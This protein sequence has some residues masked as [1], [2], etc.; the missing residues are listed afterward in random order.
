MRSRSLTPIALTLISFFF[1]AVMACVEII[2]QPPVIPADSD[3]IRFEG[4]IETYE[5]V[6]QTGSFDLHKDHA[7]KNDIDEKWKVKVLKSLEEEEYRIAHDS[8]SGK[9]TSSNS[10]N[11]MAFEYYPEGFIARP[12]SS[13]SGA[14]SNA[15][16]AVDGDE[17]VRSGEW[18]VR[19][20][21]KEVVRADHSVYLNESDMQ[22]AVLYIVGN[23][24]SSENGKIRIDYTNDMNG[25]RQDFI[26]KSRPE[27]KGKLKLN[28]N[29]RSDLKLVAGAD[30]LMFRNSQGE[31][32]LKYSALRVW[33]AEGR[34]L[35]AYFE[36]SGKS[37]FSICVNDEDA[38][39]PVTVDPLSSSP[40]WS[41]NFGLSFGST[42]AA[43]GDVNG[44]GYGDVLVGAKETATNFAS[45]GKVYLFLGSS[46]GLSATPSW[47]AVGTNENSRLGHSIAT[48]GDVNGDGYSDVLIGEPGFKVAGVSKGRVL[49]YLGSP[50]GLPASP[51]WT[52][53]GVNTTDLGR[54]VS[55]AG[56]VNGDG[57]SDIIASA[58]AGTTDTGAYN[59]V[60]FVFNGSASGPSASPAWQFRGINNLEFFGNSVC[61]AGDING[62][63]YSDIVIGSP[64]YS[65]TPSS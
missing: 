47:T 48:A 60:A 13:K 52:S 54:S 22:N 26:I 51:S 45:D 53:V 59:G 55:T 64:D 3:N 32:V 57:Y 21:L 58:G 44:D 17:A 24:A 38:I 65:V 16:Y 4:Q 49:L 62:D 31:S 9:L 37:G 28:V 15:G 10:N 42:C 30:A 25:M 43:A 20:A 12:F 11:S 35:R 14:G 41:A 1:F 63:G 61:T 8:N 56:D 19:F 2:F 46:A 50:S 18:E 33:D 36:K 23:K 34:H 6:A 27:G 39:Y 5:K 40:D 7:V 29:V